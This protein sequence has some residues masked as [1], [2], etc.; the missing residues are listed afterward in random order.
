M[1][2]RCSKANLAEFRN[3][4]KV[5]I[6]MFFNNNLINDRK[7]FEEMLYRMQNMALLYGAGALEEDAKHTISSIYE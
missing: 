3:R 7:K 6:D 5:Y 4:T 2:Q 1:E